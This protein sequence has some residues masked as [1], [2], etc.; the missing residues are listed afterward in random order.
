MDA[1]NKSNALLWIRFIYN[2]ANTYDNEDHYVDIESKNELGIYHIETQ[3]LVAKMIRDDDWV[4]C[5][6]YEN[7]LPNVCR[8]ELRFES[9]VKRIITYIEKILAGINDETEKFD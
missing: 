8:C 2:F 5:M 9:A 7:M 6:I 4:R 1:H 3:R